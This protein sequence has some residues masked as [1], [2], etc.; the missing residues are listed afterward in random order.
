MA[1]IGNILWFIFG[2][3]LIAFLAWT[4]LGAILCVTIVG[5]PFGV[6]ALRIS[7]FAAF[8]FGKELVDARLLGE[9]RIFGTALANLLWVLLAGIWLTI[10]HVVSGIGYCL[11][12][13]GIPFGLAHFKLASV[14]FAPLGKRP[15]S[16]DVARRLGV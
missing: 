8:P 4:L 2:G 9:D 6:A 12:I 14:S 16:A 1:L 11:T 10:S 15:V 3:G 7:G 5:I 13:I